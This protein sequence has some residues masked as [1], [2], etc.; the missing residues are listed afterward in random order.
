[1]LSKRFRSLLT[2]LLVIIFITIIVEYIKILNDTDDKWRKSLI[3]NN[4]DEELV[5]RSNVLVNLTN[6]EYRIESSVCDA[7]DSNEEILGM[8]NF[9]LFYFF[10]MEI[11]EMFIKFFDYVEDLKNFDLIMSM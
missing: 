6:F 1:M 9:C 2:L 5:L 8:S 10:I 4:Y 11:G 3:V 7:F